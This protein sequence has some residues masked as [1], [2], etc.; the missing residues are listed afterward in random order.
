[1]FCFCKRLNHVHGIAVR[2]QRKLFRKK[3]EETVGKKESSWHLAVIKARCS[4]EIRG[5]QRIR[6]LFVS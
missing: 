4:V 3:K 6:L 5:C 2:K 1:M